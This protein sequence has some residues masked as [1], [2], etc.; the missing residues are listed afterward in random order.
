MQVKVDRL[1]DFV[2]HLR[3]VLEVVTFV[4]DQPTD[5][6]YTLELEFCD[7]PEKD[8]LFGLLVLR[9]FGQQPDRMVHLVFAP[10][11]EF[12]M[13]FYNFDRNGRQLVWKFEC[14]FDLESLAQSPAAVANEI[15]LQI[16]GWVLRTQ[17]PTN[18]Q[19]KLRTF[20]IEKV[21]LNP[22]QP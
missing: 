10:G 14:R 8:D 3:N 5:D 22:E 11:R 17:S 9:R 21:D 12:R 1:L 2:H 7:V 13:Y 4:R 15:G 19:Q 20:V 16:A 6:R 18:D